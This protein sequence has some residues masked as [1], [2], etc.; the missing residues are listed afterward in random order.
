MPRG[1]PR[2]RVIG[3]ALGRPVRPRHQ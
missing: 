1:R 2:Q 3:D